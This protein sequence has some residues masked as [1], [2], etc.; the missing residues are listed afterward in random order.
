[1]KTTETLQ[2]FDYAVLRYIWSDN[3]GF[4]LDTRT[5]LQIQGRDNLVLGWNMAN[6]NQGKLY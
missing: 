2:D 1:M 4:D 3:S 5:Q 6:A